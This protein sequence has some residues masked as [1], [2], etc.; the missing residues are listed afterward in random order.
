[1]TDMTSTDTPEAADT[2]HR[3]RIVLSVLAVA[4]AALAVTLGPTDAQATASLGWSA[5]ASFDSGRTLSAVSC[6]SESLCVAVDHQ[7]Y[8]LSTSDPTSP[9]PSWSVAPID[10][11]ESLNAVSCAPG[12]PCV[13]VDK[14]GNAFA[15][16][17]PGAAAWSPSSV[18]GGGDLTGV[19]CPSASLCVAVDEA[20]S[21]FTSTSPASGGW[22][23]ASSHPGHLRA[24]SC[25][26]QT[27]CVAVDSVGDVLSTTTPT[28]AWSEQKLDSEELVAISCSASG[29]C[30]AV[31]H[32]GRALA[33]ADP[34]SSAPTWSLTPIDSEH[35]TAVSCAPTG[36]CVAVD[37]H[38]QARASDAP[39]AAIPLWSPSSA[40][41]GALTGVSCLAGGFC[42]AVNTLESAVGGRVSAPEAT[43][44]KPTEVTEATATLAGVVNPNDAV[45]GACLFEYGTSV[46]YVQAIPCA[47]LPA[48]LGGAQG[49]SA[50]ITGL[51]PN[52]TYHYRVT[53]GSP[54]GTTVGADEAFTTAV[55]SLVAIVHPN[56]S[57][58]GTPANG[59][60]LK[61]HPG[62]PSGTTAQLTY[63]WL[64]DM[65]PIAG[66]TR[67][68]YTVKGQDTGHHLQCQ[69]T[70][71]DGGGSATAKS[72]FVTIP[73]GGVPVSAGETA[74]GRAAFRNG[75]L[76]VPVSCSSQA[77]GGCR[78]ALRLTAVETLSGGRIVAVT[79]RTGRARKSAG[80]RHRTV[81]LV[82]LRLRLGRGAHTTVAAALGTTGRRLLAREHHFTASLNVTGT[83]I[84]VIEGQ[85]AQQLVTLSNGAHGASTH[86]TRRR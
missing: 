24:V 81:T 1:M 27:L 79:A 83:I 23:L 3:S 34:G 40:G 15:S 60:H 82:S 63:A 17:G 57:I 21:V 35:L 76:S 26:S 16:V 75:K 19:S 6:A 73:V 53:A 39:A 22:T 30:V 52:T 10:L 85:L 72:A 38:G 67:S 33:S 45:L 46:A 8:A 84:G 69:V 18:P 65:I 58:S 62:T 50:Q 20:G 9:S 66:A 44:V 56:P 37:G 61:C 54:S 14:A 74:I 5:P 42:M 12:G 2:R 86:A 11:G 41:S 36:L 28:G 80:L 51:A 78:V 64:R 25:A 47:V 59:Q 7:G 13:A 48:A 4:F 43:T 32:G 49:V 70:A 31:D 68:T 55:N 29:T 71:T 77:S